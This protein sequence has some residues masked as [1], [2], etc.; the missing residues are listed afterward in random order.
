MIDSLGDLEQVEA[1]GIVHDRNH[2]A[3]V[4]RSGDANVVVLLIDQLVGPLVDGG[5]QARMAS[6]R[7]GDRLDDERKVVETNASSLRLGREARAHLHE[8]GRVA[9]LDEREMRGGRR[10]ALHTL[11]DLAANPD[12][13][14][15]LLERPPAGSAHIL[16]RD[17]AAGPARLHPPKVDSHLFGESPRRR[18]GQWPRLRASLLDRAVRTMRSR[19][20]KSR[21][22]HFA[23]NLAY[24]RRAGGLRADLPLED[25]DHLPDLR[26]RAD[27]HAELLDPRI[28]WRSDRDGCLVGHH[29]DH[30]I[31]FRDGITR[32]DE[33]FD[34]LS[35]RDALTDVGELES[36]VSHDP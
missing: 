7:I 3:G 27:L 2:E 14:R 19:A 26:H 23:R 36:D 32:S 6:E 1:I 10:C 15:S 22:G 25:Q 34:D 11:G 5:V 9:L 4:R 31:V 16:R 30:W 24:G 18:G 35:F 17:L 8:A 21:P 12:D 29:L 28:A 20:K 13:G 33:P